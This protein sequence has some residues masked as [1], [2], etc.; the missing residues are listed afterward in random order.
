MNFEHN[1]PIPTSAD[2][3]LKQSSSFSSIHAHFNKLSVQTGG[4]NLDNMENS[5]NQGFTRTVNPLS[6]G[7]RAPLSRTTSLMDS[8]GIQRASSP[9]TPSK[10]DPFDALQSQDHTLLNSWNHNPT[11]F[12]MNN[13]PVQVPAP[14]TAQDPMSRIG[15]FSSALPS[16]S[17]M[18]GYNTTPGTPSTFT[19]KRFPAFHSPAVA[20]DPMSRQPSQW[21][22]LDHQGNIQ[23]PFDSSNMSLWFRS[24]YF[25]PA[26]QICRVGT[27]PEPLGINNKFIPLGELMA[28]LNNFTDP[29][30][31]F[32]DI[33]ATATAIP[34]NNN[35]KP[36]KSNTNDNNVTPKAKV[37]SDD[38]T[39]D[40]IL[41]LKDSEGGY[42]HEVAVPVPVNR[43]HVKKI[44]YDTIIED[45]KLPE[46]F[47]IKETLCYH[48][49]DKNGVPIEPASA[50]QPL[51]Q[52]VKEIEAVK[53]SVEA[54]KTSVEAVK[55]SVEALPVPKEILETKVEETSPSK[56]AKQTNDDKERK[57]K[58]KAE[59]MAKKLL[60][61]Q[62]R[63][64]L[65]RK[66]REEQRNLKKQKKLKEQEE[67]KS[68]AKKEA[69]EKVRKAEE[70]KQKNAEEE[71]KDGA[72]NQ[73]QIPKTTVAP[74]AGKIK[75]KPSIKAVSIAELQR[76]EDERQA[77]VE[78]R[79]LEEAEKLSQQILKEEREKQQLK[80]V[81]TWANN[82]SS[83]SVPININIKSQLKKLPIKSSPT[84]AK[85][86]ITPVAKEFE[87]PSFIE[88]QK[89]IWEQVQRTSKTKT[90]TTTVSSN[91][92][93]NAWTT[94]SSKSAMT[95]NK[96]ST[97]QIGSSTSIPG[98]KVKS[99]PVAASIPA[100]YPG[101]A[102]ISLR[103]DF[104]KWCKSQ[105][106]LNQGITATNVLEV[107]LS[108]P[109]GPEA[110][111]IIADTIYS[112]SSMMD[113]R[114]F[115]TEFVKR[116]VACEKEVNDPLSWSEALALPEGNAD[117]WEF[118]VVS[119]KKGRRS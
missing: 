115:A 66:K 37:E 93:N 97:R 21:K 99:T 89:K 106:K 98:L 62:E 75:E 113:G 33:A 74:W 112:N 13:G 32:D 40:E 45:R 10:R 34:A 114:R 44:D 107:L 119:K 2:Q 35:A 12:P 55:T 28:K 5:I 54:V 88:E 111:E 104:L 11:D 29:F 43:K 41:H 15:D 24:N 18:P 116:R 81:L 30:T 4:G 95:T 20:L 63:D 90:A 108:L 94:V 1:S 14:L 92:N 77:K 36:F 22:Y 64:E 109:A 102:S 7:V 48:K 65:E 17:M 57:L 72:Q 82:P 110:K 39:F 47:E 6:N 118:Q 51:V 46:I 52:E 100:A 53:T 9:F 23:G 42:Y 50:N 69:E 79:K 59:L 103:R 68:K 83:N 49:L 61:E 91:A 27:S 19:G 87:D 3:P 84:T 73:N 56:S 26:L 67:K 38:F 105:M 96:N 78:R 86:S 58:E 31:C 117:D 101:N 80:S 8:I 60:E 25:Q 16:N 70:K 85:A 71:D 76:Q